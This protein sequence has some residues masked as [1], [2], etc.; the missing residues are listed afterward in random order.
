MVGERTYALDPASTT[1]LPA[2]AWYAPG[3]QLRTAH[4]SFRSKHPCD[5][6]Q[7]WGEIQ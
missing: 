4:R 5:S 3:W 7:G 6:G 2:P 1:R